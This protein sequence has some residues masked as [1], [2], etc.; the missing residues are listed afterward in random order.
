MVHHGI[1]ASTEMFK[2]IVS[3]C[4][5]HVFSEYVFQQYLL[6]TSKCLCLWETSLPPMHTRTHKWTLTVTQAHTCTKLDSLSFF[7]SFSHTHTHTHTHTDTH[8]HT[9]RNALS[10]HTHSLTYAHTHT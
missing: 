1:S 2:F 4:F 5:H 10:H 3:V 8:R 7:V 6:T 9:H